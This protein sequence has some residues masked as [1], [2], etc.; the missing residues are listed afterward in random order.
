M[1]KK[2]T[3]ATLCRR[4]MVEA[5]NFYRNADGDELATRCADELAN[6]LRKISSQP[7][8]GLNIAGAAAGWRRK[9]VPHFPYHF[10]YK[11]DFTDGSLYVFL[12]RYAAKKPYA[13]S[14]LQHIAK[15]RR[16]DTV[17]IGN[18]Q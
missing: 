4:E 8:S 12:L 16:D 3:L 11:Y 6:T 9:K 2:I 5:A 7:L 15:E 13:A 18:G 17:D 10:Y 14:T 1:A